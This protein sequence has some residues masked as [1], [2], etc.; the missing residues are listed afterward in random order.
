MA[1]YF[2]MPRNYTAAAAEGA[3]EV[4]IR[5]TG[6]EEQRATVM[7]CVTVYGLTLPT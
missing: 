6:Y 4:K 5:S 1:V 3:R 2:D 7:L